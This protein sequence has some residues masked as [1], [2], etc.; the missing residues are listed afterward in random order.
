M[1]Y[2][3]NKNR[4]KEEEDDEATLEML[5]GR[6]P[7]LDYLDPQPLDTKPPTDPEIPIISGTAEDVPKDIVYSNYFLEKKPD[8]FDICHYFDAG[9]H[10]YSICHNKRRR[11]KFEQ[12][13]EVHPT[14]SQGSSHSQSQIQDVYDK[15]I[16][17][18]ML[19]SRKAFPLNVP[20]SHL[21]QMYDCTILERGYFTHS[22]N[23]TF[24]CVAVKDLQEATLYGYKTA[25]NPIPV[26]DIVWI[27]FHGEIPDGLSV[28]PVCGNTDCC[29][30]SHLHLLS[31]NDWLIKKGCRGDVIFVQ[32]NSYRRLPCECAVRCR[33]AYFH[34]CAS[35]SIV[36]PDNP[37]LP[38]QSPVRAH[39]DDTFDRD[40][41]IVAM[42]FTV[43]EAKSLMELLD[44]LF[45]IIYC[46][47]DWPSIPEGPEL[48]EIRANIKRWAY[49]QRL[50]RPSTK[51]YRQKS[52]EFENV[53]LKI[54]K[55][56]HLHKIATKIKVKDLVWRA[57]GH[58][59]GDKTHVYSTCLDSNCYRYEHL[60]EETYEMFLSRRSCSTILCLEDGRVNSVIPCPHN[61]K[62]TAV[63]IDSLN[64]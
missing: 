23:S 29:K 30:I 37:Q 40:S 51:V 35:E 62:C 11:A 10:V 38:Y 64:K 43:E 20:D 42:R 22:Q 27:R 3:K 58:S 25:R 55:E 6:D 1:K 39:K 19:N 14:P 56:H 13:K 7:G 61:I 32:N 53:Y 26:K 17:P 33:K 46:E 57:H 18:R 9:E 31:K 63:R 44:G 5:I 52:G 41:T 60:S 2:N 24:P 28:Y 45:S 59:I 49:C 36:T 4:Y 50:C 47:K 15:C 8:G 21:H 16:E 54:P 34:I 48:E 12:V